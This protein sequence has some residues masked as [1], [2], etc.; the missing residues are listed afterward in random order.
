MSI[1]LTP[2]QL[3]QAF[4]YLKRGV[5]PPTGIQH[6]TAGRTAEIRTIHELLKDTDNAVSR[7]CFIEASYGSGKSH[8][9]KATESLAHQNRFAVSW[10]TVNGDSHAF[11]HPTRYLHKLFESLSVPDTPHRGLWDICQTWFK[12]GR[13]EPILKWAGCESPWSFSSSLNHIARAIEKDGMSGT[14]DAFYRRILEARDLNFSRGRWCQPEV[15]ERL[16]A[17]GRLTRA[18]GLAGTVFL[19]DEMETIATLLTNVRSRLV[20]YEILNH[21]TDSRRFPYCVFVF[22][23][24]PD[25]DEK[26]REEAA[27]LA[28]YET[29]YPDGFR[30]STKWRGSDIKIMSLKPIRKADKL[31][32]LQNL[33]SVHQ[34]AYDWP[35]DQRLADAYLNQFLEAATA[36]SLTERETTKAFVEFLE[37]AQQNPDF[38]PEIQNSDNNPLKLVAL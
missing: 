4:R 26:L 16:A 25:F 1:P 22:A 11:N 28:Y 9:L 7:H 31:I 14:E 24:T 6:F 5:F 37:I 13:K 32:F 34:F 10:V 2:Q 33:R 19:F 23:I 21:F 30:F 18:A 3:K 12:N 38:K 36:N 29:N 27:R 17:L 35:A 20:A 15:Y 8:M